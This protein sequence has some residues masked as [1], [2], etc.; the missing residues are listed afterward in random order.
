MITKRC[1]TCGKEFEVANRREKSARFCSLPCRDITVSKERWEGRETRF[2]SNVYKTDGCWEW[3]GNPSTKFGYCKYNRRL[4]HRLSWNFTNGDIP[5][6]MLV[7]HRC[8]NPK[9]VRPD[10]LFLGT[11]KDNVHDMIQKG[12]ARRN[13]RKGEANYLTKI[14]NADVQK[15][16]QLAV[17]GTKQNEIARN[18]GISTAQV[19]RIV[20]N[21]TRQ[22]G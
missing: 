5:V 15:I 18:F 3:M 22:H 8:D 10:H 17:S 21:R 1:E 19:S 11:Q 4:V 2:W 14:S 12:R 7:L 16:R 9:C 20:N 13:A 6:G